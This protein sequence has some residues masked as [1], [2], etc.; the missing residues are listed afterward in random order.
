MAVIASLGKEELDKMCQEMSDCIE[1]NTFDEENFIQAV[2][3]WDLKIIK[4]ANVCAII[5]KFFQNISRHCRSKS[6]NN[7]K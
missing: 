5:G 2:S 6:S 4:A 1:N 3:N 7:L